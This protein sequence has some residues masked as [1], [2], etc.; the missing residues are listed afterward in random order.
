MQKN[1]YQISNSSKI[2]STETENVNAITY[3]F[4]EDT[5]KISNQTLIVSTSTEEASR[6]L[7]DISSSADKLTSTSS[8]VATAIEEMNSSL[9]EIAQNCHREADIA[10]NAKLKANDSEK[11]MTLLNKSANAIGGIL[12]IITDIAEQT[13]LLA[14]NATIEAASAGDAGKGFAVVAAEVKTLSQQTAKA[15]QN[16]SE[17]INEIQHDSS[18]ALSSLKE[19]V[20]VVEEVDTI[21]H[22][23]ASAVEE[24]SATINEI[25]KNVAYSNTATVDISHNIQEASRGLTD[26][27]GNVQKINEN[28]KSVM[29]NSD[30]LKTSISS[31]NNITVDLKGVVSQFKVQ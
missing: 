30:Q 5:R 12:D 8:A 29:C 20:G 26:I 17:K 11:L 31:L 18:N 28:A 10:Q 4:T 25:A 19:I 9:S 23:I 21:S 27:S 1:I 3:K 14:L 13:N 22:S 7:I 2:V 16:I 15:T 24:Q 6:N